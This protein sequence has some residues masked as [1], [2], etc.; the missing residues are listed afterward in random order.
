M[1]PLSHLFLFCPSGLG[2]LWSEAGGEEYDDFGGIFLS[3]S[4]TFAAIVAVHT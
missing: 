2:L 4:S 3:F 1:D